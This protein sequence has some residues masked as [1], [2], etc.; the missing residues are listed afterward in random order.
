[1]AAELDLG[2]MVGPLPLGAWVGAVGVGGLLLVRNRRAAAAAPTTVT[3][4]SGTVSLNGD[5]GVGTGAVGGWAYQ[6]PTAATSTLVPEPTTNEEWAQ[7]RLNQL[8][9]LGYDPAVADSALRKY[10]EGAALSASEYALTKVALGFGAPPLLLPAPLFAPP[11]LPV[12]AT[13]AV[14]PP[15]AGLPA[16][17]KSKPVA[18]AK[19]HHYTVR[20]GD[21]LSSIGRKYHVP[22]QAIYNAN[23]KKI[24]NPNH[25]SA[26]WVLTIPAS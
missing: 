18:K 26:G 25:I 14:T 15:V 19:V 23:K 21:T 1:M 22:W 7:R 8:I 20:S 16:P 2:K 4:D 12:A 6:S 5:P 3:G 10:L 17:A 9:A 11:T 13:P 24:K